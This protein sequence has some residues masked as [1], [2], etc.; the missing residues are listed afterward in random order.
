MTYFL[1]HIVFSKNSPINLKNKLKIVTE[2]IHGYHVRVSNIG[3]YEVS[4][5]NSNV[6]DLKFNFVFSKFLNSINFF[7]LDND[8]KKF[9]T[10]L[11]QNIDNFV[12]CFI[13]LLPKFNVD[14]NLI[15]YY[16]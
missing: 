9:K 4:K 16:N 11:N 5:S 15:L 8:F 3:K 2:Q 13:K 12:N 14:L 10:F 7:H 1:F 6:G